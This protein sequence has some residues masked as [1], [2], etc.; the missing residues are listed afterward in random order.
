MKNMIKSSSTLPAFIV[1]KK[2]R[3]ARR[4][5]LRDIT[6]LLG[7]L[8]LAVRASTSWWLLLQYVM[9]VDAIEIYKLLPKIDCG[10][11]PSKSCIAH[12]K[13]VAEDR[14][15]LAECIRLMPYGLMLI[16][17]LFSQGR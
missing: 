15:R 17:G 10:Q 8:L 3:N 7:I 2:P 14:G 6:L 16:A 12:A 5:R 13:A 9:A 1:S 11:C 4:S